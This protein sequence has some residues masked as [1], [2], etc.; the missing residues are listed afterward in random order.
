MQL[1]YCIKPK[2]KWRTVATKTYF[3]FRGFDAFIN[4]KTRKNR[5]HEV[6]ICSTLHTF[7]CL[8]F[9]FHDI[10]KLNWISENILLFNDK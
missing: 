4:V 10:L 2:N 7:F 1:M 6:L 3:K 9:C 8:N 5:G